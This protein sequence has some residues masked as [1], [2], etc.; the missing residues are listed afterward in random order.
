MMQAR[1]SLLIWKVYG[2]RLDG[3]QNDDM[4]YEKIPGDPTSL[5]HQGKPVPNT[6]QNRNIMHIGYTGSQMPPPDAVKSGKV[7]P[8]SD[9]DRMTLVR[10]VDLG[11]PIDLAADPKNPTARGNGWMLDDVR[12]TR[13]LTEP[14]AGANPALTRIL[15]GAH[16]YNTGLDATGFEVMADFALDGAKP[17]ENLAP[18]FKALPG[19]RWVLELAQPVKELPRGKL[20]VSVKDKQGNITR[21][22]RTF[23]VGPP[24]K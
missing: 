23:S 3:W 6:P 15:V 9:E 11:C 24:A 8:L 2:E 22:D 7:K 10:W 1:R 20:T 5:H 19:G 13:A 14:R 16:D 12:P 4:P 21:I 18:K 17:G